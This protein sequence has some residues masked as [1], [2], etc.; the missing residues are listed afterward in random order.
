MGNMNLKLAE[1]IKTTSAEFFSPSVDTNFTVDNVLTDSRASAKNSLFIALRGERF[2]AHDFIEDAINNGSQIIMVEDKAKAL[3][4]GKVAT[5]LL[6]NSTYVALQKVARLYRDNLRAKVITLTGSVGKTS[7]KD[8]LSQALA[9]SAK[10][11]K[12]AKNLNNN[13][14]VA[15]TIFDIPTDADF[16]VLE[17]GMDGKGQLS[18]ISSTS[19]PDL[20]IITNIGTSHIEK[21]GSR[22]AIEEAKSE[23]LDDAKPAAPLLILAEDPYL[24]NLALAQK[25]K[26][27]VAL[28][29]TSGLSQKLRSNLAED[30]SLPEV[31]E[32]YIEEVSE[33]LSKFKGENIFPNLQSGVR[34]KISELEI[35]SQGMSFNFYKK[36]PDE[37]FICLAK[38]RLNAWGSQLC[39][40]II[41][42]LALSDILGLNL[43]V[44][45]D[46]FAD[47]LD[48]TP[49]RQEI[50]ELS[51]GNLLVNDSYNASPESM[52]SAFILSDHLKDK[53][54][55]QHSVAIIGGINELGE[56]RESLHKDVARS[57][58]MSDFDEILLIGPEAESMRT[59]IADLSESKLIYTFNSNTEIIEYISNKEYN[60][61]I[62]LVKAS[63]GFALEEVAE[64]IATQY[65]K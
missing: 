55:Y 59:C 44:I 8:M 34:Y 26:R 38:L 51:I 63:R 14:G 15:Y 52:K 64:S 25:D 47:K 53:F 49:G 43:K 28:L 29:D 30:K 33:T 45:A 46:S 50:T 42:A 1:I 54:D 20:V 58:A 61:S 60:N 17:C 12:T 65:R 21:L 56:Y 7:T 31:S 9:S 19:N 41:F 3:Q 11:F 39:E 2:D 10:V 35:N 13:Y 32:S 6:V 62:F 22:K 4:W 5:V 40:N 16:A 37:K 18:E 48:I 36:L 24:L 23:I 27:A 57:L